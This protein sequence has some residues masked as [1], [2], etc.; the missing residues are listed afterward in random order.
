M[1]VATDSD[2]EVDVYYPNGTTLEDEHFT[3]NEFDVF[4]RDTYHNVDD[5]RMDLTGTQIVATKPVAVYS[6]NGRVIVQ[7][8][9][10]LTYKV[11]ISAQT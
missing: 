5:H 1:V 6:G 7:S 8:T 11:D 4:S 2:T 3:L 10:R 9:V